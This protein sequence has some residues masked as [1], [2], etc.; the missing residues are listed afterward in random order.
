MAMLEPA[1]FANVFLQY[2]ARSHQHQ[3]T[4]GTVPTVVVNQIYLGYKG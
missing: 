1:R 4:T 2:D 3:H